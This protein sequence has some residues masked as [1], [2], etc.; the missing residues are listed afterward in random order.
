MSEEAW[1][2]SRALWWISTRIVGPTLALAW[3]ALAAYGLLHPRA[4]DLAALRLTPSDVAVPI[5][6][7]ALSRSY[8]IFPRS[9]PNASVSTVNNNFGAPVVSESPGEAAGVVVIWT[10]FASCVWRFWAVPVIRKLRA[11]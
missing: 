5:G 9:L 4:S 7:T 3:P 10:L 2:R 8:V 6:M 1:T 11:N